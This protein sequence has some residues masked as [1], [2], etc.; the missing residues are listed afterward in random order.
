MGGELFV[1]KHTGPFHE[2]FLHDF[3]FV[4]H[5]LLYEVDEEQSE[6]DGAKNN[7]VVPDRDEV[8]RFQNL[9]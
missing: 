8:K 9:E 6:G 5:L 4:E 7:H 2:S 1:A 3:L